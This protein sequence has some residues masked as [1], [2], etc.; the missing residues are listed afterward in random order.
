MNQE[1]RVEYERRAEREASVHIWESL[2][3]QNSLTVQEYIQDV[4]QRE[5][6]IGVFRSMTADEIQDDFRDYILDRQ[7]QEAVS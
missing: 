5:E 6:F 3:D 2:S 7:H 1:Q 4:R